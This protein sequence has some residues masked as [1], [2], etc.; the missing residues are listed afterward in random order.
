MELLS[1][2]FYCSTCGKPVIVRDYEQVIEWGKKCADCRVEHVTGGI[3]EMK[4]NY[5]YKNLPHKKP[6]NLTIKVDES[7]PSSQPLVDVCLRREKPGKKHKK[8]K[9][10]EQLRKERELNDAKWERE[11]YGYQHAYY[12]EHNVGYAKNT[13]EEE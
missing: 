8:N 10:P 7:L 3:D 1:N 12:K 6:Y 2:K 4:R 5:V 13:F 11:R 9:S